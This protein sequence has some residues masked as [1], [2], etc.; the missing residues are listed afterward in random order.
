L[1]CKSC[2]LDNKKCEDQRPC[3]R[4]VQRGEE[5]IHV[6]RRPKLVKVRCQSCREAKKRCENTRPC[7]HCSTHG[8]VCVDPPRKG[9][10]HGMRVKE[11]CVNCRQHKVRCDGQRPCV[12]CSR[13]GLVCQ[14]RTGPSKQREWSGAI[15]SS[16]SSLEPAPRAMIQPVKSQ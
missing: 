13:K 15:S 2:R 10:G 1:A 16:R 8:E 4:C 6:A 11:A 3:K 5:C 14:E 9:K 12:F 7:Y